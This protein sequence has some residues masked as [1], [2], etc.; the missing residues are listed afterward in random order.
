MCLK[1]ARSP[2]T[3]ISD[4]AQFWRTGNFYSKKVVM[5]GSYVGIPSN[6]YRAV[7][8]T[9]ENDIGKKNH[10]CSWKLSP[11]NLTLCA[12]GQ[13]VQIDE[14]VISRA[15]HNRA[16]TLT[17]F[18][19]IFFQQF[20]GLASSTPPS[21]FVNALQ[22]L[23]PTPTSATIEFSLPQSDASTVLYANLNSKVDELLP[24]NNRRS[25][26]A[27]YTPGRRPRCYLQIRGQQTRG[28]QDN[29]C[30]ESHAHKERGSRIFPE[31]SG[32]YTS[33]KDRKATTWHRS[34][35]RSLTPLNALIGMIQA[36]MSFGFK[37][38]VS[39]YQYQDDRIA[40]CQ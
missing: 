6:R 28:S 20:G 12:P 10:S 13:I 2:K 24:N 29:C 14:S 36:T 22:E 16:R 1:N 23:R 27:E 38:S 33:P 26:M 18:F 21:A 31:G 11:Q 4:K 19:V 3:D 30:E 7:S 25:L 39:R 5:S 15:M 32:I 40:E 8:V 9:F 35:A 37:C 17:E 34:T